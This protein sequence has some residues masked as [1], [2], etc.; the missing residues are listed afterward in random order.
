MF[1]LMRAKTCG[2]SADE[3]QFRR[4]HY[5]GTCKTIGSL[6][7]QK[8]RLLLNH[9][10]VFLAE[11]LTSLSDEN[12]GDWQK[13]YQSYNCLSLPK[14]E[15]PL[16]LQFAATTNVILTEFK[17]ADHISD[18]RQKRFKLA[19]RI[20][21]KE[22]IAAEKLLKEWNFPLEKVRESLETQTSVE[23]N[24]TDLN[25]LS[26]PTAETTAIF[27]SEGA[28]LIG[29]N[30]LESLAHQI[31]FAFGKLVYLLDAFEDFERDE[32]RN[33]F[34]A[35]RVVFGKQGKQKSV[36]LLLDLENEIIEQIYEL[37]ISEAKK[38]IFSSRLR[39]NLQKK[40]ETKLPNLVCKPKKRLTF[41]ERFERAKIRAQELTANHSWATALPIF[42]FV[43]AFAFIS[44]VHAR[45]AKSA[46]E[47]AELSFNLMFLGSIIGTVLAFPKAMMQGEGE[48]GGGYTPPP[49][50]PTGGE[51]QPKMKG[52][53]GLKGGG[54]GGSSCGL[55]CCDCDSCECCC[56]CGECGCDSCDCCD[57]GGCCDC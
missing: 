52:K 8:S 48:S 25:E 13:S 53:R 37:P 26:L 5:C 29:R 15:M 3:K 14:N 24:S 28:K 23:N 41:S 17:I 51:A 18:T 46:R 35:L 1:G 36:S 30:E 27:F 38:Q 44:P 19:H 50:P 40:I 34:N 10:T 4:L 39:S 12:V 32:K 49:P 33:Q 6:Y 56:D 57:C 42:I 43:L 31:G 54:T 2:M 21:S 45:E 22:F 47:C 16:S 9:D 11:I 7:G 20:F 55:C